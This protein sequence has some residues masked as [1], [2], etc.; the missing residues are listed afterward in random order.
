MKKYIIFDVDGTLL[1]TEK[2]YMKS[3]QF[4]LAQHG[5]DKSYAEVYKTFGLP[6]KEALEYFDVEDPEKLQ[7]EWQ[8]HYHDFWDDVAL[9]DGISSTLSDLKDANRQLAIVT[10]NT[11][12]EFEDHITGFAITNYFDAFSFA[13]QTR[14]MKPFP[15]PI[16]ASLESLDAP[17]DE[18]IY[19]GDSIHDMKA[20]HAAGIDFGLASWSIPSLDPFSDQQEF[21]FKRPTDILTLLDNNIE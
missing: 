8:S 19:I 4:T 5:I 10:S 15:D 11:Q 16:L 7:L 13:G 20:A 2:M 17:A 21:T 6:S 14:R 3:L 9:F 18:A 1:D 12:A